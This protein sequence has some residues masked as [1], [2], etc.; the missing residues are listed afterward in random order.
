[1]P[2]QA[3]TILGTFNSWLVNIASLGTDRGRNMYTMRTGKCHKSR[4][5]LFFLREWVVKI[6]ST[7]L[8]RVEDW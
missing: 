6:D 1:M 5:F 3:V 4:L 8:D 7:L 2:G